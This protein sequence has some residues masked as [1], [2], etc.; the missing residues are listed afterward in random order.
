[1]LYSGA[2]AFYT[3]TIVGF[4]ENCPLERA[5]ALQTGDTILSINGERVYMYSDINLLLSLDK[6]GVYDLRCSGPPPGNCRTAAPPG[7]WW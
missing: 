2:K 5:D 1:M 6:D 4:A 7:S 3:P